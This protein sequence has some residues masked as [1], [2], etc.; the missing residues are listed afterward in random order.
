MAQER[1]VLVSCLTPTLKSEKYLEV[2]LR[3]IE[4]QDLFPNFE[5]ILN[6][7]SPSAE[8]FR[9]VNLYKAK[10]GEVLRVV[11]HDEI[12]PLGPAWNQCIAMANAE[13][14]AI[15]NVD[16]LRTPNSLRSQVDSLQNS[17]YVVSYGPFK[18]V[19]NFQDSNGRTV[20]VENLSAGDFLKGMYFGPFMAFKKAALQHSGLFDEQLVSGGDFDL[21]IRLALQGAAVRVP[22]LLGYYLDA[23]VGASTAPN[24][25]QLVER[26]VIEL[27]YGIYEKV[28]WQFVNRALNYDIKRVFYEEKSVPVSEIR[29]VSSLFGSGIE[30]STRDRGKLKTRIKNFIVRIVGY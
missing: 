7:S 22:G 4:R 11:T 20:K 26:T 1:T 15:W 27:R 17:E 28:D 2:F 25:M 12:Q 30:N 9:I 24:S 16:D 8:E 21:S 19:N 6:M 10:Y 18:I 23:G 13:I 5:V 14:L 29:G 3:E